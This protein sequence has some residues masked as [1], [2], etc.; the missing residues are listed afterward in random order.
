MKKFIMITAI[1]MLFSTNALAGGMHWDPFDGSWAP[2][3]TYAAMVYFQQNYADTIKKDGD[4]LTK[5]ADFESNITIARFHTWQE[6]AGRPFQMSILVPFGNVKSPAGNASGIGDL[7]IVPSLQI[8]K[9]EGGYLNFGFSVYA[10]TGRY[11]YGKQNIGNNRWVFRPNVIFSQSVKRF[12][13]D[14]ISAVE[15]YTDNDNYKYMGNKESLEKDM[16]YFTDV[17]FS[18][19]LVPESNTFISLGFGGTWGG[20]QEVNGNEVSSNRADYSTKATLGTSLTPTFQIL[21]S[22]TYDIAV[23]NG[24]EGYGTQIRLAKL[25]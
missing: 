24:P 5:D 8:T 2:K 15:Y 22:I 11:N 1:C 14:W 3:G 23:E 10:P 25:F 17:H 16:E 13:V 6:I 9:W 7:G 18:Y 21:A 4:T 19:I 20:K 12:R